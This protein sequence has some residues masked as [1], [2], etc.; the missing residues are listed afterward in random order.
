P[1]D[2]ESLYHS[3]ERRFWD[4]AEVLLK[5]GGNLNAVHPV[6]KNTPLYF[7]AR[8]MGPLRL[9]ATGREILT[10]LFRHGARPDIVCGKERATALHA[11]AERGWPKDLI[12]ILLAQGANPRR[13]DGR[14]R[15]P[16]ALALLAG[17]PRL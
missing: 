8:T 1:N 7:I 5:H 2:G 16:A 13:K 14:G 10:W 4:C 9:R 15:T 6:Y 11:A 17:H 3:V 12:E